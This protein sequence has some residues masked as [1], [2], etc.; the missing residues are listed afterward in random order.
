MLDRIDKITRLLEDKKG[1][2]IVVLDLR[3]VNS[4][5]DCFIIASGNSTIH[6][7]SLARD[8]LRTMPLAGLKERNRPDL[9]S[10]WIV[11]DYGDIIVHVF[12]EEMRDF[13]QLEKLWG[14]ARAIALNK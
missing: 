9:N 11:V 2:D 4:Y 6:C 14:D 13:Y 5:L 3:K 1:R 7:R 10:S 12:T 8:L